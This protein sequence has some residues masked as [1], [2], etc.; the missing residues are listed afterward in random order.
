[1]V[2]PFVVKKSVITNFS[3]QP[4]RHAQRGNDP[5]VLALG[6]SV[7]AARIDSGLT[8]DQLALVSGVS[9]DTVMALEGGR[10]SITLGNAL[11]VLKALGLQLRP[12][13]RS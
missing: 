6:D 3:R 12:Q 2:L 1:M 10:G 13:E 4:R 9:R 7:R 11:R 8:Q 5:D